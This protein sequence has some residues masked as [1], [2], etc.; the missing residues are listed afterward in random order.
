MV[1]QEQQLIAK[2]VQEKKRRS[3]GKCPTRWGG[4]GGLLVDGSQRKS[5]DDRIDIKVSAFFF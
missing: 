1:R 3:I 4:G 2:P 5:K